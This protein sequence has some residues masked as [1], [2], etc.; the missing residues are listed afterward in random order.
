MPTLTSPNRLPDA[1][2]RSLHQLGLEVRELLP[3]LWMRFRADAEHHHA[4]RVCL[5]RL[6]PNGEIVGDC[7]C[8]DAFQSRLATLWRI[9]AAEL[10]AGKLPASRDGLSRHAWV[11]FS[12]RGWSDDDR[13]AR[14]ASNAVADPASYRAKPVALR[15]PDD[16]HRELLVLALGAA[17]SLRRSLDPRGR[18]FAE[19]LAARLS[20]AGFGDLESNLARVSGML[21]TVRRVADEQPRNTPRCCPELGALG[22]WEARVEHPLDAHR[23]PPTSSYTAPAADDDAPVWEPATD[24]D[25]VERQV[26]ADAAA[27]LLR[28]GRERERG[29]AEG[30]ATPLGA[31][32][33]ERYVAGRRRGERDDA[34]T[35]AA[36]R[37]AAETGDLSAARCEEL[38]ADAERLAAIGRALADLALDP[39]IALDLVGDPACVR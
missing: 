11:V 10:E 8:A 19:Y 31:V 15:L 4:G 1:G 27:G 26:A 36:L 28:R 33:F 9:L 22:W 29:T 24:A 3:M 20:Q 25:I 35:V 5:A 37:E 18:E 39:A 2:H 12:T 38:L 7:D 21:A 6:R 23:T 17:G 13:A 30:L 32:L 34:S 16:A 14:V